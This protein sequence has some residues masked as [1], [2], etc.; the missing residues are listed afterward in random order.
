MKHGSAGS[1]ARGRAGLRLVPGPR[2]PPS[3]YLYGVA[4]PKDGLIMPTSNTA[5]FQIFL[6]VLSPKVSDHFYSVSKISDAAITEEITAPPPP[7]R[8]PSKS[9]TRSFRYFKRRLL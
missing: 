5:C 6:N 2:S 4:Y 7:S 1:T 3:F 9:L 8:P